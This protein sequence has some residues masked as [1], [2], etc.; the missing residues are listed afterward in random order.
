M[1]GYVRRE[2]IIVLSAVVVMV[3]LLGFLLFSIVEEAERLGREVDRVI[4]QADEKATLATLMSDTG[5]DR[6]MTLY[7][8][9]LVDDPF[10]RDE[11]MMEFYN[12]AARHLAART[13]LRQISTPE[14]RRMLDGVSNK[15][16]M[17]APLTNRTAELLVDD[18][19]DE[20][21][22]LWSSPGQ[23][24]T[25]RITLDALGE[26]KTFH[27]E[28]RGKAVRAAVLEQER[29]SNL[30]NTIIMLLFVVLA[31]S[32]F[33][34][35]RFARIKSELEGVVDERVAELDQLAHYDPLTQ[36]PN[37]MFF[38]EMLGHAVAHAHRSGERMALFFI[39]LD[40]FK[41]IND[42]L[43]HVAGDQLLIEA[44]KRL[45]RS[46]R[47]EDVLSRL[48]GDEFT[49]LIPS[50]SGVMDLVEVANRIQH[51][52]R[53]PLFLDGHEVMV[54]ASIGIAL[55]PNGEESRD[56]PLSTGVGKGGVHISSSLDRVEQQLLRQA[57]I[58]MYS[59]KGQGRGS[60]M[61]YD[62]S[63]DY[64][65]IEKLDMESA[66]M[67][68]LDRGAFT[69]LYHP[70]L[71]VSD[72]RIVGA[73]ALL[74]W[75][76]DGE[77]VQPEIFVPLLEEMGEISR[78]GEWVLATACRQLGRWQREGFGELRVAVN[79]SARQFHTDGF[80]ETIIN[81]VDQSGIPPSSLE[82][83]ITESLLMEDSETV[84]QTLSRLADYGIQVALDDFGTGYSS[85]S[86]L[87]KFEFSANKIDRLFISNVAAEK[88]DA[89]L[90]HS[91]I[92]MGHDLNMRVIAEG[93][94]TEEQLE[95]LR[96]NGCDEY[97]G[98]L[99]SHPLTA[100]EMGKML[101]K[102]L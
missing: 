35:R 49:V 43:G 55:Y 88:E 84:R 52:I 39:D 80:D 61:F 16:Q 40:H 60:F 97:Q 4:S 45:Q 68:A 58:A 33:V 8:L 32:A 81:I 10:E 29:R 6:S 44:T 18:E 9:F 48:G 13:R 101:R 15:T 76:H 99:Y 92:S 38:E 47:A 19:I 64:Q 79:L 93:V 54:G 102:M 1:K 66:L 95:F 67:G 34:I 42:T 74:R 11:I 65:A 14:E 5:N 12:L 41:K 100:E 31:V 36:I 89:A 62:Q 90:T 57:D 98:F 53:K 51:E 73:E 27:M 56:L 17:L 94:E 91:I 24:Q 7:R 50:F 22:A 20:A 72:N 30:L 59:V 63:R 25:H 28:Q 82:I 46:I 70:Q 87:K 71:R 3:M 69:I 77:T 37:R 83:E 26:L 2:I 85:L 23:L 86:Y 78:V 21:R 96:R 75:E